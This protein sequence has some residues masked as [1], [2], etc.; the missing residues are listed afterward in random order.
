MPE[1]SEDGNLPRD[2]GSEFPARKPS[3]SSN[4]SVRLLKLPLWRKTTISVID[5]LQ[6]VSLQNE[7]NHSS[8]FFAPA[9]RVGL[10][11][12]KAENLTASGPLGDVK[13][14]VAFLPDEDNNTRN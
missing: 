8:G 3:S 2:Q 13:L 11:T 14:R 6:R 12:K 5:K 9:A 4:W 10:L 1:I 7:A